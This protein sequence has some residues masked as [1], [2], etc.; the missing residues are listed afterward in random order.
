MSRG[1]MTTSVPGICKTNLDVRRQHP[2]RGRCHHSMVGILL[3]RG[4]PLIE[5][6]TLDVPCELHEASLLL[7][8]DPN[9]LVE[10][11]DYPLHDVKPC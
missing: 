4:D 10:L 3:D 8:G 1:G 11:Q 2:A 6:C 9:D 5:V 7:V